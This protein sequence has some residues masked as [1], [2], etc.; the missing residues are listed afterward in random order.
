[1]HE[2]NDLSKTLV[3]FDVDGTLIQSMALEAECYVT[4]FAD[5]L[6]IESI[7]SDWGSYLHVTDPG[8]AIE[9]YQ[10]Y[11]GRS[12]TDH[13]LRSFHDLFVSRLKSKIAKDKGCLIEV[14][15]AADMLAKLKADLRFTIAIATGAWKEPI[16]VKLSAAGLAI[17][18][19]PFASAEDSIERKIIFSLAAKRASSSFQQTVLVG[20]GLWDMATARTLDYGFI[21]IG[22]GIQA[23]RLQAEG[24]AH[25]IENYLDYESFISVLG[26]APP[27]RRLPL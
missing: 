4:A 7:S 18:D 3:I 16:Q 26:K 27:L 9:L 5:H 20:D 21:G 1:M 12:P 24:A 11:C 2:N 23:S 14:A 17:N 6:G 22:T 8:I 19:F 13:E 10:R 15:G 25:V